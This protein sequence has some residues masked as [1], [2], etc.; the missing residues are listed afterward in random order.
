M[1]KNAK[2]DFEERC[3]GVVHVGGMP[4][5]LRH[6]LVDSA[7]ARTSWGQRLRFE[8]SGRTKRETAC[9]RGEIPRE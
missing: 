3:K 9:A 8:C 4:V 6:G 7:R 5:G 2:D 1:R